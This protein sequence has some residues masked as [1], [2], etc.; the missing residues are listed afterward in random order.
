MEQTLDCSSVF[1]RVRGV[2]AS[3]GHAGGPAR[4]VLD[5]GELGSLREG[6]VAVLRCAWPEAAAALGRVAAVVSE[7]GGMLCSLGTVA[8]ESAV[9]CIVGAAGVTA[10]VHD[11]D[12]LFVDADCGLILVARAAVAA[13]V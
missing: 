5:A 13:P 12:W 9:P 2:G 1:V 11:G 4:I 10:T 6:E 3:W 8:R 7:R